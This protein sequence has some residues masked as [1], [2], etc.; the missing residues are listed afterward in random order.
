MGNSAKTN[1]KRPRPRPERTQFE[2]VVKRLLATPPMPESHVHSERRGRKKLG[3][4]L[5][6]AAAD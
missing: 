2:Q 6:S 4:V 5:G 3:K 1:G